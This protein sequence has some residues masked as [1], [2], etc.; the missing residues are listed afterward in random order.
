MRKGIGLFRESRDIAFVLLVAIGAVITFTTFPCTAFAQRD[1]E[2]GL[3]LQYDTGFEPSIAVNNSGTVL[4]VHR[5]EVAGRL[6]YHVGRV[7]GPTIQWGPSINYD[8]GTAA[9][10]ALNNN[11][12]A[13]EVHK[14]EVLGKL[15]YHVGTVRGNQLSWSKSVQYDTGASP[16]VAIN[17]FGFVVEVHK[18]ETLPKLY[19]H[20]GKISGQQ[21]IWGPSIQ[22]DNGVSPSVA[23]NNQGIVIE[24]HQS[25]WR[26][27]LFYHVGR[28]VNGKVQW[29]SSQQY[30][31]GTD[32]SVSITPDGFVIE[33]HRSEKSTTLWRRVGTISGNTIKWSGPAMQFDNGASPTV[34]CNSKLAIQVHKSET[35]FKLY[36]STSLITDRS[37]WMHDRLATL[38]NRTLRNLTIPG[39]HD[40]GMYLSGIANYF[41]QTQDR[42]IF[43]QL[44]GGVR[45]FDL[46]PKS[47]GGDIIIHHGIIPGPSV[48]TVLDDVK[49]FLMYGHKELIVLKFSHFEFND[50]DYTTLANKIVS[51]L[52]PF[53]LTSCPMGKRLA[54]IPLENL[55]KNY[56]RVI[57]LFDDADSPTAAKF[58][59]IGIWTYADAGRL[60]RPGSDL[61]VFDSYADT[62]SYQNMKSDQFSKFQNYNGW[63]SKNPP[64]GCDLF[65]LSWT[66]TP[67]TLVHTYAEIAN[68]QLASAIIE[69]KIPNQFNQR[70][71]IVYVDYFE[72][73]RVTDV[74]LY[75]NGVY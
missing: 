73:A 32:P 33:V 34:A 25:E 68:A 57:V 5:S 47:S 24:V 39:S 50:R 27:A 28:L 31:S 15:W 45:Y 70:I 42:T 44:M 38:G 69:L 54:D 1:V 36:Y 64:I 20:V 14:S 29:G 56:G 16:S 63:S 4:E 35:L 62:I 9:R 13:V 41:G 18:S 65:L 52:T 71:N 74:C 53:L 58:S 46:R 17:D 40:A 12:V 75:L 55:I 48:Q 30:D 49:R 7:N 22:Y 11:N 3:G 59:K 23:M 26:P 60:S 43:E 66:L 10:C 67:K 51:T 19:Y 72:M 21:I 37:N 2:F 6:W 8:T 61:V